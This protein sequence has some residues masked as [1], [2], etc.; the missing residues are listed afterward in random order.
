[1]DTC[2][3]SIILSLHFSGNLLRYCSLP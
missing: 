3:S 1:M 2:I